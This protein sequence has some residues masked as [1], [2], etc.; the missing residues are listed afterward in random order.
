[1]SR[2]EQ[3]KAA[4]SWVQGNKDLIRCIAAPYAKYMAIEDTDIEH[5]ATLTA[6]LVFSLMAEKGEPEYRFGA[7]F[8][9]HFRNQ[10]YLMAKGSMVLIVDED[11][12][13][14]TETNEAPDHEPDKEIIA[15]ALMKMTNRQRQVSQWI[16]NQPGPVSTTVIARHFGTDDRAVRRILTHAIKRLEKRSHA[17]PTVRHNIRSAA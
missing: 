6:F 10:C 1:M 13:K 4:I 7:Y 2:T 17:H 5:E 15:R 9:V 12:E 11:T 14:L 8:R 3:W 16:L